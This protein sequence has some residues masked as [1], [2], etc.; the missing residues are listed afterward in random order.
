MEEKPPD[1]R[2]RK[3]GSEQRSERLAQVARDLQDLMQKM[4]DLLR[5]IRDEAR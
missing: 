2:A 1:Q 3:S 5:E 4:Q